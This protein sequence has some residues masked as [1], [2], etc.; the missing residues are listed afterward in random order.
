MASRGGRADADDRIDAERT[1][2]GSLLRMDSN[3]HRAVQRRP[4]APARRPRARQQMVRLVEH[5][6]MRTSGI[7][8]KPGQPR[9]H[10][11][12]ESG[13]VVHWQTKQDRTTLASGWRRTSRISSTVGSC[14]RRQARWRSRDSRS[15]PRDR[16]GRTDSVL[17]TKLLEE[18]SRDAWTCRCRKSPRSGASCR[19]P[20][21]VSGV[22]RLIVAEL[23]PMALGPSVVSA[24][25][26]QAGA[27]STRST[28]APAVRPSTQSARSFSVGNALATATAHSHMLRNA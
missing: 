2:G 10:A 17:A 27:R 21:T 9:Q 5:E 25:S 3:Q 6:P 23:E 14:S 22:S 24:G 12:E 15:R 28:P 1:A 16:S 8:E 13:P 7:G 11:G 4:A 26:R 19:A 20:G 18:R